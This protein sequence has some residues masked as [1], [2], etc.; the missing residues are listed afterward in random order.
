MSQ[1][2][3]SAQELIELATPDKATLNK[4]SFSKLLDLSKYLMT[5]DVL[6]DIFGLV[7]P[8][9]GEEGTK[10]KVKLP[11]QSDI[12]D[13]CRLCRTK[14]YVYMEFLFIINK[15]VNCPTMGR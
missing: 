11:R 15:K 12:I 9:I 13:E 3:L 8:G 2:Q 10:I 1:A 7:R 4:L 14:M 6:K 5:D